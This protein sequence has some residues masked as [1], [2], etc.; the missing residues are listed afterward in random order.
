MGH[1][2]HSDAGNSHGERPI[3]IT[4]GAG[5]IGTHLAHRPLSNGKPVLLY[6]NLSRPGV[7][8]NLAWLRREHGDLMKFE[9]A[10][11]RNREVLRKVVQRASQMRWN[12]RTPFKLDGKHGRKKEPPLAQAF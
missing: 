9:L 5:F 2:G 3:L 4:G 12:R 1:K 10:D 11:T 8:H 7:E 6:D